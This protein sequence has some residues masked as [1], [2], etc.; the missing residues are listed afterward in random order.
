MHSFVSLILLEDEE[1]VDIKGYMN[2]CISL[3]VNMQFIFVLIR[4]KK[5]L[6]LQVS[7]NVLFIASSKIGTVIDN[8]I[9]RKEHLHYGKCC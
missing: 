9:Q 6:S 8:V 3:D 5:R 7:F 4:A 1:I 2:Y